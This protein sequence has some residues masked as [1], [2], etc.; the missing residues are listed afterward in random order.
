MTS[1]AI[2]FSPMLAVVFRPNKIGFKKTKSFFYEQKVK[3]SSKE[4]QVLL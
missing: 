3:Q 4:I 2:S 1:R